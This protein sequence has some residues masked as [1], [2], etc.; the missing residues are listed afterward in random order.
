[1]TDLHGDPLRYDERDVFRT[2]GM[3]A[4]NGRVHDRVIE[5]IAAIFPRPE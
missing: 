1:M 5:K 3:V 2:R 4:T